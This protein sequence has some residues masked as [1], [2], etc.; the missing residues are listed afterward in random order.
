M[1]KGVKIT[2]FV[3]IGLIV[4][5]AVMSFVALAG[6]GFNVKEVATTKNYT[7]K[8]VDFTEEF[9]NINVDMGSGGIEV[10]KSDNDYSSFVYYESDVDIY[11]TEVKDDT[12]NIKHERKNTFASWFSFDINIQ[13]A[14]LYL[15]SDVYENAVVKSGSGSI[16]FKDEITFTDVDANTGSG[17]VKIYGLTA[18]DLVAHSNSGSV[19]MKDTKAKSAD[20]STGS[21]S[22]KVDNC[23]IQTLLSEKT[24]SGSVYCDNIT[25]NSANL[26]TGSGSVKSVNVSCESDFTANTSSG[27][28]NLDEVVSGNT[29]FAKTGSGSI[30]LASSD[31]ADMTLNTGSGSI[32][33]TVKT[34]KMWDCTSG[35]GSIKN[36]ADDPTGGKCVAHTGSGSIKLEVVQ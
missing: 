15:A 29:F 28:I 13:P 23:E 24:N 20:L 36:P 22:V 1:K 32:S 27:S 19:E 4:L 31:G 25:C 9:K 26:K 21:G 30:K 12:L 8:S 2:I 10:L 17:S 18:N 34:P 11:K 7:E 5:G 6:V 14:R 35:S 16:A 33:G 3:S